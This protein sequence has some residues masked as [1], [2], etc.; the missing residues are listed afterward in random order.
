MADTSV[1]PS[2]A[3]GNDEQVDY[4]Q[5]PGFYTNPDGT[6]KNNGY[7][8]YDSM[9]DT[10]HIST[11]SH[12]NM[13]PVLVSNKNDSYPSHTSL[14]NL[15]TLPVQ[16]PPFPRMLPKIDLYNDGQPSFSYLAD[17]VTLA[18]QVPPFP[19]ML[20]GIISNICEGYPSTRGEEPEFGAGSNSQIEEIEIP[21]SVTYIADYAFWNSDITSVKINRHCVYFPHSFPPGCHI[22]PYNDK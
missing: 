13:L 8:S 16:T 5:R 10:V 18:V 12:A 9:P 4:E 11:D 22:K 20:P 1:D 19:R 2:Q 3:P 21:Y 17:L 7:P 6:L 15:V 14:P